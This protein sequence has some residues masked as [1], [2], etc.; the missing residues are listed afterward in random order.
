MD[1]NPDRFNVRELVT[2]ACDTGSPLIQEGVELRQDVADDIGEANTDKARLQQMVINLL[3]NAIKFTD[4]GEVIVRVSVAPLPSTPLR[5]GS[6]GCEQNPMEK[7]ANGGRFT[8]WRRFHTQ[9]WKEICYDELWNTPVRDDSGASG[10][11]LA[12]ASRR[13]ARRSL[14]AS[15]AR[16]S[17]RSQSYEQASHRGDVGG[18]LT[19]DGRRGGQVRGPECR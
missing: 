18:A 19:L 15:H 5:A 9:F 8:D 11:V 7:K 17:S 16:S 6:P 14:R 4:S 12:G 10:D 2:S 3:S 1:V 13:V